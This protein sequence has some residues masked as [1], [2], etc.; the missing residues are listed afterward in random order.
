MAKAIQY[1]HYPKLRKRKVTKTYEQGYGQNG[2][3]SSLGTT[4]EDTDSDGVLDT[5]VKNSPR[6]GA[7]KRPVGVV[8]RP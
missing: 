7:L 6:I 1:A 5:I 2:G 3:V 4:Y 8:G